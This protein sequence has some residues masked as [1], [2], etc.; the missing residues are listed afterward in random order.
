MDDTENL[1][2]TLAEAEAEE[3]QLAASVG[4]H[5]R[6]DTV[7]RDAKLRD[8]TDDS[9]FHWHRYEKVKEISDIAFP[10]NILLYILILPRRMLHSCAD[11]G[12]FT[13]A[14]S[15]IKQMNEN[16]QL[17]GA[18]A[19]HALIFSYVKAGYSRGALNAIRAEVGKGKDFPLTPIVFINL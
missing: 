13:N 14:E 19:Y 10:F 1:L 15:I 7:L 17:P 9:R 3:E 11:R 12:D 8:E 2:G 4:I 5:V 18:K 6:G 16:N